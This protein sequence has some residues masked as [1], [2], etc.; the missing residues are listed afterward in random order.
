[1]IGS[2]PKTK[3]Q[4]QKKIIGKVKVT[5]IYTNTTYERGQKNNDDDNNPDTLFISQFKQIIIAIGKVSVTLLLAFTTSS[6]FYKFL[7]PDKFV[8]LKPREY[9]FNHVSQNQEEKSIKY[10]HVIIR[11]YTYRMCLDLIQSSTCV[12][13]L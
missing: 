6:N 9:R 11:C 7:N 12:I 3:K 2:H 13:N 10:G 1:M 8:A 4:K 5:S